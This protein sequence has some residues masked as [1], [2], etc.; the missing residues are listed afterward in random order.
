M[1]PRLRL[2]GGPRRNPSGRE[3]PAMGYVLMHRGL[4]RR[5]S[6]CSMEQFR[7]YQ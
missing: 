6:T 2:D 4:T 1:G 3:Q 7:A 5:T